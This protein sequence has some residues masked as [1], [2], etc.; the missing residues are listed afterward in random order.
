MLFEKVSL[1]PG[2]D[3]VYLETYV[4]D[5]LPNF[6]RKAILVIPGGGYGG[7][8]SDREGEPIA[9]AF[10]PHG[11]NAFVLHYS[12]ARSRT[13]PDQLIEAS[14]A[15]KHIR[16]NAER[17]NIDP[18]KV[19]VIGFSAGGHLAGSLGVLWHKK[20]IYEALPMPEGYNKPTGMMLIYPVISGD[21]AISH[22]GSFCNL[23]GTDT[24]TN[25][26]LAEASLERHVDE[27][28][29]PVF[30]MHTANDQVVP[31]ENSLR[32]AMAYRK[33]G[34]IFELHV[35]PDAPHGI[36]LSNPITAGCFGDNPRTKNP[37]YATWVENA[38]RWADQL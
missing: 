30:L 19:F 13:F 15:M 1:W 26:Q 16:D 3:D 12:V 10:M 33:A 18:E 20:G 35:Y 23:F 29:V 17:Y 31:I 25:E 8:C 38:V 4:A 5:R 34:R 11:Y 22:P 7:V 36:A 9:M 37:H 32:M 28:S 27:R 2:T 24:P 14:A 21:P 6:T